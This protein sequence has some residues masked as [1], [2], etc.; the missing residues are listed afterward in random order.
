MKVIY[1]LLHN[2]NSTYGMYLSGVEILSPVSTLNSGPI[3]LDELFCTKH[4][5]ALQDCKKGIHGLGLT[6]CNH[7]QDV[8]LKCNGI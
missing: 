8:W 2:I 5:V 6:T 7:D 4:D 3:Y 1:L